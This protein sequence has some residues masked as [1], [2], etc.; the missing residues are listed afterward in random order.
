MEAAVRFAPS[1]TPESRRFLLA[2][3]T[4]NSIKHCEISGLFK[5]NAY[6]K[7]I[8]QRDKL[9]NFT[10]FDWYGPDESIIAIGTSVG[11]AQV[12]RL[13][14]IPSSSGLTPE[15]HSFPVKLQ[16]RCNSIAFNR[17]SLL[18]VGLDRIRGDT[19]LNVHDLNVEGGVV[20]PATRLGGAEVVTNVKFFGDQ[21]ELL[22]AGSGGIARAGQHLRL[23]DLRGEF[24]SQRSLKSSWLSNV[25]D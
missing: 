5:D 13:D 25:F 4:T 20:E 9:P 12:L 22:L 16:R 7:T 11:E 19:S 1:S 2:D 21:P 18:A 6:F 8:T 3:V 15:L 14:A 23:Y 10:A 24:W 17:R